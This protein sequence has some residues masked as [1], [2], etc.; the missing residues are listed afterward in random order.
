V[1][2]DET[3]DRVMSL[4]AEYGRVVYGIS[5]RFTKEKSEA[6]DVYQEAWL[7]IFETLPRKNPTSPMRGWLCGV[8]VN[9]AR[10]Y[11]RRRYRWR[12]P[13]GGLWQR[14]VG[15][16]TADDEVL[17]VGA[18]AT[19]TLW[20]AVDSLSAR[21]REIFTLYELDDLSTLD[22]A[23]RLGVAEGTVKATI[24][25][26]RKLLRSKVAPLESFWMRGEL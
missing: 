16:V 10:D 11:I 18:N 12:D 26:T 19:K 2:T 6:D 3:W 24:H 21:Q 14:I 7:R 8:T 13:R 25:Q 22:I 23:N 5:M 9:V 1:S 17:P 4:K 20:G 15:G